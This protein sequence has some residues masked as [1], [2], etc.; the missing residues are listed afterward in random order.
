MA[1]GSSSPAGPEQP[2][3]PL[4][5]PMVIHSK[6]RRSVAFIASSSTEALQPD[7]EMGMRRH[8]AGTRRDDAVL[9]AAEQGSVRLDRASSLCEREASWGRRERQNELATRVG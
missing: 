3:P 5:A 1:V 8:G 2:A 7:A 9:F 6:P 4:A